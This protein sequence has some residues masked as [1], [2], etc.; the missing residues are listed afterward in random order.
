MSK[1]ITWMA[2]AH[3][4]LAALVVLIACAPDTREVPSALP[5][6]VAIGVIELTLIVSLV[7]ARLRRKP[8]A[9]P[10]LA[11]AAWIVLLVWEAATTKFDVVSVLIFP[12]PERVFTVFATQYETLLRNAVYS[13]EL[14]A[15]GYLGDI[16]VGA[17]FGVFVGWLTG[18]RMFFHP[19]AKVLAP[20][21]PLVLAPYVILV[22]PTFRIASMLLIGLTVFFFTFL[23]TIEQVSSI[24][25]DLVDSARMMGF[26]QREMVFKVAFPAVFPSVLSGLKINLIMGF[27]MLIFA[28]TLGA[29]YGLGNWINVN[30]MHANYANLIAGFIEIGI[31]ITIVNKIVELAQKHL[32]RW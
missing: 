22:A 20:I 31:I 29:P 1:R 13:L 30:Q 23:S 24:D 16:V 3:T 11:L 4:A 21:P 32:V 18:L 9:A 17:V 26:S 2:A 28:E 27:M 7:V 19:I 5:L 6:W 10:Q 25:G 8:S 15:S 12:A 14:L